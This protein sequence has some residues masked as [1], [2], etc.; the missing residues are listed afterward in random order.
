MLEPN[1]IPKKTQQ[2]II[3]AF[4]WGSKL[5]KSKILLLMTTLWVLPIIHVK[6]E[7][8]YFFTPKIFYNYTNNYANERK[9]H[10]VVKEELPIKIMG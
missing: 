10:D 3:E 7:N 5:S 4:F 9:H 8:T 1:K 2:K 6:K